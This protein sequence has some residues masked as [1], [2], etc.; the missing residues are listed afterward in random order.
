MEDFWEAVYMTLNGFY[1]GKD[2]VSGVENAF[3]RGSYCEQRYAS[4]S[5]ARDRLCKRL[6]VLEEDE[7]IEIILD[8][9]MRITEEL[10]RRMYEYGVM[11]HDRRE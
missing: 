7:D 1:V 8:E 11:F 6:G 4:L 9:S 5:G 3:S 10:C 2:A